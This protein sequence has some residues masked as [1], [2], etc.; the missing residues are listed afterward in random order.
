MKLTLTADWFDVTPGTQRLEI[1]GYVATVHDLY[2]GLYEFTVLRGSEI[3]GTNSRVGAAVAREAA[4]S[5][6]ALH[7]Q[8]VEAAV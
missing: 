7:A 8:A 2:G 1:G 5:M 6:I 4:E 3:V